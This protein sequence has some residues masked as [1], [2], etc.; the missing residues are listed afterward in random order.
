M[1][2][3]QQ[4][5]AV[6]IRR[7]TITQDMAHKW[8]SDKSVLGNNSIPEQYQKYSSIFSEEEAQVFPPDREPNA[9]IELKPGV[10][11][12]ID[13]KVYPLTLHKQEILKK[14]LLEELD[15]GFISPATS[16]YT[17]PVF[18]I[19]KKDSTEKRLV[20]DYQKLNQW[21]IPDNG[22]LN[23]IE[24]LMQQMNRCSLFKFDIR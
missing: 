12:R 11:E 10:P 18:F 13:C 1:G 24:T 5:E 15:K 19:V 2:D 7:S 14:F 16:P 6:F 4:D 17:S 3:L 23:R 20:I 9:T 8:Q 22:P 21:M